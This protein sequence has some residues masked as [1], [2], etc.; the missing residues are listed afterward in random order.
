METALWLADRSEASDGSPWAHRGAQSATESTSE[1][2]DEDGDGSSG[3]GDNSD[4]DGAGGGG[5]GEGEGERDSE[6]SELAKGC[7]EVYFSDGSVGHFDRIWLATGSV[8]DVQ[9]DPLLGPLLQRRPAR[10]L[11]LRLALCCLSSCP[12]V[13]LGPRGNT[14]SLASLCLSLSLS[15]CTVAWRACMA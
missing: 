3:D 6:S 11:A 7:W 14:D 15:L 8:L 5:G 12:H 10:L 1:D 9:R 13:C 4:G 2:E